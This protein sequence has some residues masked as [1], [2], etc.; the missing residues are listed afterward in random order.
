MS[1]S[2]SLK[3]GSGSHRNKRVPDETLLQSVNEIR[4]MLSQILSM[5]RSNSIGSSYPPSSSQGSNLHDDLITVFAE[6]VTTLSREV[7]R[8]IPSSYDVTP[9][10][11]VITPS[12]DVTD[13]SH[14][15]ALFSNNDY[16]IRNDYVRSVEQED[17][18]DTESSGYKYLPEAN[19]TSVP[20]ICYSEMKGEG[21]ELE[22]KESQLPYRAD[23]LALNSEVLVADSEGPF[24]VPELDHSTMYKLEFSDLESLSNVS[25]H[26]TAGESRDQPDS[27]IEAGHVIDGDILNP[28][29]FRII[30]PHYDM[31]EEI[32][33]LP[34]AASHSE[35]EFL[36]APPSLLGS[37]D[38]LI[39]RNPEYTCF[40]DVPSEEKQNDTQNM[41]WMVAK[42]EKLLKSDRV[43]SSNVKHIRNC[44]NQLTGPGYL[45][46][47]GF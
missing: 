23:C 4:D 5:T 22:N 34:Y 19:T 14:D 6:E 30:N 43:I 32:H 2:T 45:P 12:F 28:S 33:P 24:L 36:T 3:S 41:N 18:D 35:E 42:I 1:E 7:L 40:R 26:E 27:M 46:N 16:E 13:S 29:D 11:D 10:H 31:P 25:D 37:R 21:N 15:V 47:V 38:S 8:D 9:S 44:I 39:A 20:D 17:K